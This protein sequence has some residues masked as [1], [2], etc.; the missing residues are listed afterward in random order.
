M[1]PGS[2]RPAPDGDGVGSD[3]HPGRPNQAHTPHRPVTPFSAAVASSRHPNRAGP[4][5]AA[6]P[7]TLWT[8]TLGRTVND[9]PR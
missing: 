3:K 7:L 2:V 4:A 8:T 5:L 6:G 9:Q 1:W